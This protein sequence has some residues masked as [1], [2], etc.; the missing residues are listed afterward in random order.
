[1]KKVILFSLLSFWAFYVQAQVRGSNAGP[2]QARGQ[3]AQ[4]GDHNLLRTNDGMS[5]SPVGTVAQHRT[6]YRF[7]S[8]D[9]GFVSGD[10]TILRSQDGG[11]RWQPAY[12]CAVKVEVN[13][14]T[15]DVSCQVEKI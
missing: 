10:D 15:R 14:L 7:T 5:W 6:D 4:G 2:P 12:R 13:G 11:R 1:M 9:V 3:S 8:A